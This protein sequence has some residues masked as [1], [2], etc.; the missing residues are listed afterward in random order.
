[1]ASI[2]A[3][4]A[5]G[6][7]CVVTVSSCSNVADRHPGP[8]VSAARASTVPATTGKSD[9]QQAVHNADDVAFAH[10]M[11]GAHVQ[12]AQLSAM[13]APNTTDE[14]LVALADQITDEQQPQIQ[15]FIAWLLQWGQDPNSGPGTVDQATVARL[16]TLNGPDFDKLWLH[17]MI[18]HH[19]GAIDVAQAELAR[20][21]NPDAKAMA[22]SIIT[23]QQAEIARMKQMLGG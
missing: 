13:V 3:G 6:A 8:S 15:A 22:G 9:T 2:R 12:A 5:I 17:T 10:T 4:A 11:L 14:Q 16:Q 7:L 1:M 18:T 19:L 23:A 20:G 21:D